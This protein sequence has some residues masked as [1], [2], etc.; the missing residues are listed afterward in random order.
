VIY[1]FRIRRV[2]CQNVLELIKAKSGGKNYPARR[3]RKRKDSN[4]FKKEMAPLQT[5]RRSCE[6]R[7]TQ[8]IPNSIR[9]SGGKGFYS[10]LPR[11]LPIHLSDKGR[12]GFIGNGQG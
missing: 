7:Q 8:P 10:L 1:F 11:K 6:K 4:D 9:L 3:S 5:P 2:L 12:W